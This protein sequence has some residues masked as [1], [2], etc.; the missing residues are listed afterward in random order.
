SRTL[1]EVFLN[2]AGLYQIRI[3]QSSGPAPGILYQV[4]SKLL[5]LPAGRALIGLALAAGKRFRKPQLSHLCIVTVLAGVVA[6]QFAGAI[7]GS[8]HWSI[9]TSSVD[10]FKQ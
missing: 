5:S 4:L 3:E 9:G 7:R 8:W 6:V 10:S 1:L 2:P